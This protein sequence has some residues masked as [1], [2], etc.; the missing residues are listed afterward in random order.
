[1]SYESEAWIDEAL[2]ALAAD[3]ARVSVPAPL[4]FMTSLLDDR[5]GR[6]KQ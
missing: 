5:Q 1:M 2:E 4:R 6:S 3:D